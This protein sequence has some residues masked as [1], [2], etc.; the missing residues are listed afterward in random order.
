MADHH[1]GRSPDGSKVS[2]IDE[3]AKRPFGRPVTHEDAGGENVFVVRFWPDEKPGE[4]LIWR[5][6]VY[7]VQSES[8]AFFVDHAALNAFIAEALEKTRRHE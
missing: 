1:F 7:H 8:R 2:S 4:P 6:S 3:R 5:G